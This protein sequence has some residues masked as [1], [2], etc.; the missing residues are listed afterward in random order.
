MTTDSELIDQTLGGKLEAFD[1]LM[2]RY[3]RLIFKV[4]YG[5]TGS[6]EAALD[7][8]QTVFL[9]AYRSLASFRKEANVKTW[10]TRIAFNEATNWTRSAARRGGTAIDDVEH[11]LLV[12]APQ[13]VEMEQK[14]REKL[15]DLALAELNERHRLAVV[16]RYMH[17]LPIEEIS[18]VLQCSEGVTKNILFRSVRRMREVLSGTAGVAHA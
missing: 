15:V 7:V 1:E 10:L 3:E 17:G 9:N 14:D 11:E 18:E 6:R 16:L 12:D 13:Q 2:R 4:A 8:S 5:F